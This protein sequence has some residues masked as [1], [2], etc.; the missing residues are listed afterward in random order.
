[1]TLVTNSTSPSPPVSAAEGASIGLVGVVA[2]IGVSVLAIGTI[3]CV[4]VILWR[5]HLHRMNKKS[6]KF[7]IITNFQSG[8][9]TLFKLA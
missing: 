2:G 3:L 7:S 8:H 1:M 6:K 4:A 9:L 5:Y